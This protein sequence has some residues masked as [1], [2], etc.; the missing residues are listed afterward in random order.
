SCSKVGKIIS[1]PQT[2]EVLDV[3]T[4]PVCTLEVVSIKEK[5]AICKIV[6][7]S[8]ETLI[9]KNMLVTLKTD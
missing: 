7:S 3:A 1:D 6:N 4:I 5:I 9:E 8:P 2:G